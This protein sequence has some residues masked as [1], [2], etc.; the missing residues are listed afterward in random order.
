MVVQTEKDNRNSD[1]GRRSFLN[2]LW[3]GLGLVVLAEVF[4]A[5]LSLSAAP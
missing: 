4:L 2:W 3:V 1:G 5:D